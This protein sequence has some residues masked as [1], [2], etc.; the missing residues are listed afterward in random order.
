IRLPP[1]SPLSPYTTL[2]RSRLVVI[3]DLNHILLFQTGD[4][5]EQRSVIHHSTGAAARRSSE[6]VQ[7]LFPASAERGHAAGRGIAKRLSSRSEE[8]R[9]VNGSGSRW[10]HQ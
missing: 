8:R 4:L 9:V 1:R 6:E 3:S 7:K 5:T 10:R 2:F